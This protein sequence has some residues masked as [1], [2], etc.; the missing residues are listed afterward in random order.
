MKLNVFTEPF[1][2][3]ILHRFTVIIVPKQF[4]L[5]M[6]NNDCGTSEMAAIDLESYTWVKGLNVLQF[7]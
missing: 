6:S 3:E 1:K 7:L 4:V 2:T 5:D